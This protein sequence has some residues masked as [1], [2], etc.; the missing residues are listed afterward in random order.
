MMNEMTKSR[1]L[2][3]GLH[4]LLTMEAV[5]SL[6]SATFTN[7]TTE[8]VSQAATL[9]EEMQSDPE[10]YPILMNIVL[11]SDS[12]SIR[13]SALTYIKTTVQYSWTSKL[14]DD[15]KIF[16]LSNIPQLIAQCPQELFGVCTS[17]ANLLVKYEYFNSD[18]WKDLPDIIT[19]YFASGDQQQIITALIFS[20]SILKMC[21]NP[22]SSLEQTYENVSKLIIPKIAEIMQIQMPH[23][24]V[25]LEFHCLS[26]LLFNHVPTIF[27]QQAD[28]FLSKGF[29]YAHEKSENIKMKRHVL[30]FFTNFF[31]DFE[32]GLEQ[33]IVEQLI[34][35]SHDFISTHN[36]Q[37]IRSKS[38]RLLCEIYQKKDPVYFTNNIGFYVSE[39]LPQL[40]AVSDEDE[41]LLEFGDFVGFVNSQHQACTNWDE[42]VSSACRFVAK[43]APRSEES[44]PTFMQYVYNMIQW[45]EQTDKDISSQCNVY[46]AFHMLSA[47]IA[48]LSEERNGE[49]IEFVVHIF[50]FEYPIIRAAAFMLLSYINNP[51]YSDELLQICYRHLNDNQLV[52]YY[53]SI[54]L[55]N[56][57]Q[58]IMNSEIHEAVLQS[59]SPDVQ[60]ILSHYNNIA[61]VFQTD[62]LITSLSTIIEFFKNL[63]LP[64]SLGIATNLLTQYVQNGYS[65]DN[66][67]EFVLSASSSLME[68]I[69]LLGKN[70]DDS[71]P[72]LVELF[73]YIREAYASLQNFC[74]IDDIIKMAAKV[75]SVSPQF[76]QS[77]WA[78]FHLS[79]QSLSTSKFVK[80]EDLQVLY[81]Q[82]IFKDQQLSQN[83]EI[84]FEVFK[85]L[86][87][88]INIGDGED[89]AVALSLLSNL[90][91]RCPETIAT[92][93]TNLLNLLASVIENGIESDPICELFSSILLLINEPLDFGQI[94]NIIETWLESHSFPLFLSSAVTKFSLFDSFPE[95]QVRILI[96]CF[97]SI[98]DQIHSEDEVYFEDLELDVFE[99]KDSDFS[100]VDVKAPCW[101]NDSDIVQ[102]FYQLIDHVSKINPEI[103]QE[104]IQSLCSDEERNYVEIIE[105]RTEVVQ[106]IAQ[107]Q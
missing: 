44:L 84:I 51:V 8:D 83:P 89:S 82:L 78:I 6:L 34:S 35:I 107:Q 25:S 104:S 55:S 86:I 59:L 10:F 54:C 5:I 65:D 96:N 85:V 73:G 49:I 28:L 102:Q 14:S 90:A 105:Q 24:I 99:S 3:N 62:T 103:Y 43:I 47:L 19:S 16:I 64:Y 1:F 68:I 15:I 52:S 100:M 91:L 38:L 74:S 20:R 69:E 71:Q 92:H 76:D 45:F 39:L 23:D 33:E 4:Q 17:L 11:Q 98:Y 70:P 32:D 42:I 106:K 48:G 66:L 56:I 88:I 37:T 101:F 41:E 22:T 57:L 36:D 75:V 61:S 21:K 27:H 60:D 2:F 95:I 72:I 31:L 87:D 94:D 81:E 30:K 18:N 97:I 63:I 67:G 53:S 77:Y 80:L 13:K 40:F 9:L 7:Q 50:E 93:V 12:M 58:S 29:I 79:V 26:R 46:A